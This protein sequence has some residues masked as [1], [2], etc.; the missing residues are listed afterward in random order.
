VNWHL[1]R[2]LSRYILVSYWPQ[3]NLSITVATYCTI[4]SYYWTGSVFEKHILLHTSGS[5]LWLIRVQFLHP[6]PSIYYSQSKPWWSWL[7]VMAEVSQ[8]VRE[9]LHVHQNPLFWDTKSWLISICGEGGAASWGGGAIDDGYVNAFLAVAFTRVMRLCCIL[10]LLVDLSQVMWGPSRHLGSF[11]AV[12]WA[13]FDFNV[14][15]SSCRGYSLINT[16]KF[17]K[18]KFELIGQNMQ[19]PAAL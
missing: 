17:K 10:Q 15:Y 16:L 1:L 2:L 12:N 14:S 7:K 3:L 13:S 11:T 4:R 8:G 5:W 9:T 18:K 6:Y 19:L